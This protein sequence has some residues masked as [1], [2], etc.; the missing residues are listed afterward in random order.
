MKYHFPYQFVDDIEIP[1]DNLIGIYE[2]GTEHHQRDDTA[3]IEEAIK[4]PIGSPRIKDMLK[5]EERVLIICDDITRPTPT[6]KIIPLLLRELK[7]AGIR[8]EQIEI[9]VALGTHRKMTEEEMVEKTGKDV[10]KRITI[11]N[12]YWEEEENLYFAG[13]TNLGIEIWPNK[14]LR[15]ADFIIGIGIIMPHAVAGFSG[16]GKIIVPGVCGERTCGEMHW[17]MVNVPTREIFGVVD[18]PVRKIIDEVALKAGLKIILNVVLNSYGELVAMVTGHPIKAHREG[19]RIS[20]QIHA[21]GLPCQADI[22]IADSYGSDID[23]WQAVK[24]MTPVDVALKDGGVAIQIAA[25]PEGVSSSHPEVLQFGYQSVQRILEME[26]EGLINKSVACH[27]VQASRVIIDRGQGY[28]ITKGISKNDTLKLGFKY[29]STPQKALEEA[30]AKLGKDAKILL[31][32][33]AG[34]MLPVIKETN[35][36]S[37]S[38]LPGRLL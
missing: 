7:Q 16:G 4:N 17:R 8:E 14:K 28:L 38:E 3:I 19:V 13:K 33:K 20:K 27:A 1:D 22:V 18:N 15:A 35:S 9:L 10:F 36:L 25:C 2:W 5:R 11:S 21:V 30:L 23:Y 31:L 6:H 26:K 37:G 24:A 29:A 32:R 12:H 34:G